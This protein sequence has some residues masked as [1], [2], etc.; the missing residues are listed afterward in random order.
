MP[1]SVKLFYGLC[2]GLAVYWVYLTASFLL[3]PPPEY[4]KSIAKLPPEYRELARQVS[5]NTLV[6]GRG[7][8]C[9][10]VLLFGS[11]AA[12]G[13]Q[14]WARWTLAGVFVLAEVLVI[15]VEAYL[16][17]RNHAD[18]GSAFSRYTQHNWSRPSDYIL[19]AVK[20][21]IVAFA[22]SGN[23][24]PWFKRKASALSEL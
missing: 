10:I 21:A 9:L 22:F 4:L 5:F 17:V 3:F 6:I 23:A 24:R 20:I 1:R 8:W 16:V 18:I 7:V 15:G 11:L 12:F 14:N 19:A 2:I 13:R